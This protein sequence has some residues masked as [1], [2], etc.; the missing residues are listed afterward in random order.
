MISKLDISIINQGNESTVNKHSCCSFKS[1]CK[2][3]NCTSYVFACYVNKQFVCKELI[4]RIYLKITNKCTITCLIIFW[5]QETILMQRFE[6]NLSAFLLI[7]ITGILTT[8]QALHFLFQVLLGNDPQG[9]IPY[10][11]ENFY[12][13]ATRVHG[14]NL[15][16]FFRDKPL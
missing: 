1:Y 2:P 16:K 9:I 15:I 8:L 6:L 14:Q 10:I 13:H 4:N 3:N 11:C 7:A 12:A 5:M